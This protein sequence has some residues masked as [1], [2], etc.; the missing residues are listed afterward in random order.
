MLFSL[1]DGRRY[2]AQM[3]DLLGDACEQIAVVGAIRRKVPRLTEVAL[4]A[5]PRLVLTDPMF[6]LVAPLQRDLLRE[7]TDRMLRDGRLKRGAGEGDLPPRRTWG[8]GLRQGLYVAPKGEEVP[9]SLHWA[10][11]ASYGLLLA[12]WTGPRP[13]REQITTQVGRRV[14]DWECDGLLPRTFTYKH[15]HLVWTIG[16]EVMPVPDE[17]TLERC[18]GRRLPSP[19]RRR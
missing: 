17:A 3:V 7:C 6:D 19:S 2:A 5:R 12:M 13:F 4:V 8:S 15:G 9:F 1:D 16:G 10:D 18:L 14:K 11:E